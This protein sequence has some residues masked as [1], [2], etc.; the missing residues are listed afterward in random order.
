M[1]IAFLTS[2]TRKISGK[3]IIEEPLGGTHSAMINLAE[4]FAKNSDNQVYIFC[5]C[6]NE[7]GIYNNVNY[8]K[9]E[10]IIR[11]SKENE[12]DYFICV[13]SE[14]SLRAGL[15][16]KKTILWLHNDYS[17]YWQELSDVASDISGLMAVKSD[18]VITVSN[19][20]NQVIKDVFKI[21]DNH[22]KKIYNGI[23]TDL[24]KDNKPFE[25]RK[26]HLIYISAP[27]RGL[28]LLLDFFPEIK[29]QIPDIELHVYSSFKTW[30]KTDSSFQETEK[31]IMEKANQ[32]GIF[33]HEPLPVQQL[34]EKLKESLLF[35]YPNHSS[36]FSYFNSETF[37]ISAV[38]AQAAGLPVITSSRGALPEVV[39]NN[40]TGILIDGEPYSDE[41]KT[42]FINTVIKICQD[43]KLWDEYSNNAYQWAKSFSWENISKEWK[44]LFLQLNTE[45]STKLKEALLKAKFPTPQVSIIIP[46]YN[47]ANN[48]V[49]VLNA[50]TTQ[51][52][53]QFE[54]IIADDGSTDN[55]KDVVESFR[56]RLNIRYAYCGENKGFRA[57]RTRNIGL[58]KARGKIIVFLDSDVV[59]P[60][61][62]IEE[63]IKA[64]NQYGN[65]VVN[66]FVYRMKEYNTDDLGLS[67]KEFIAKHKENLEDDIK[68]KFNVF[69][70]EPIE[71]GYYLDSN[72]LSIKADHIIKEGFDSSFTGWGHEDTELGYRFINKGFKFLFLKDGIE[73]YHIHHG[74]RE[75][76]KEE[77]KVNWQRLTKKYNLKKWYIP[78]PSLEVEGMIVLNDF[79]PEK[80]V[81]FFNN[82]VTAKFE[83][84]LGDKFNGLTP[85]KTFDI[86][87]FNF[88][89]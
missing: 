38:E 1:I 32:E 88:K 67:P 65:I 44:A 24:F 86:Q 78:L 85:F 60:S 19:W 10:K 49:Y 39:I 55:T 27:D 70:R 5:N 31:Q 11:F 75:N 12:I 16:A 29:K 45:E 48:L 71:E 52:Y 28:D 6:Q 51:S 30:G 22:L 77:N 34:S 69:D 7:E 15:K 41:Y 2:V 9:L 4:T 81:G 54:V 89:Q 25:Q 62:Y 59:V 57:A 3:T 43:K 56:D 17:P 68:Y 61:N 23:N 50:L 53:S 72:S 63:H 73:S 58:S 84:K 35:V 80:A 42:D 82:L 8:L 14:S 74:I 18:K 26:K 83:I 20:H 79:E 46:T 64:H 40:K 47:R 76:K 13:A 66:T 36:E 37:C 87:D 33:I 21:P